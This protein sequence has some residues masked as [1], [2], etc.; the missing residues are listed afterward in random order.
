MGRVPSAG[1]FCFVVLAALLGVF[2][3][4]G[5]QTRAQ[6]GLPTPQGPPTVTPRG[7]LGGAVALPTK[8]PIGVVR[9]PTA[10][11]TPA[12]GAADCLV[13][14]RTID[15]L[16]ALA[17][18]AVGAPSPSPTQVRESDTAAASLGSTATSSAIPTST[19]SVGLASTP[20][21]GVRSTSTT[22]SEIQATARGLIACSNAGRL[23]SVWAYF[24]DG[25]VT[26]VAEEQGALFNATV[27]EATARSQSTRQDQVPTVS[28]VRILSDGRVSARLALPA[29]SA[30]AQVAGA[31][32]P[33]TIV[34]VLQDG[35]WLIDEVSPG[36]GAVGP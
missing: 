8:T 33:V 4:R 32:G 14:P 19:E 15:E 20:T 30:A 10:Q 5:I 34:F 31:S 35:I 11:P 2:A 28:N 13:Q 21:A 26:R 22:V 24:S 25:F 36:V 27:L 1:I 29:N 6:S 17:P 23:L 7:Q 18:G 9:T 16:L 3:L 12:L